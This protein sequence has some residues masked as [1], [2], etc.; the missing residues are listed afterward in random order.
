MVSQIAIDVLFVSGQHLDEFSHSV[1]KISTN[2]SSEQPATI[3]PQEAEK[4]QGGPTALYAGYSKFL[5]ISPWTLVW[6]VVTGTFLTFRYVYIYIY[7]Y[8]YIYIYIYV[9]VYIYI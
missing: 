1:P 2:L 9:Y 6:L 5:G 4:R 7:I 8:T 3:G